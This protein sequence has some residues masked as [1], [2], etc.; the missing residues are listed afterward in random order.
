MHQQLARTRRN[1]KQV[2]PQTRK[3]PGSV[4]V[5]TL[6]LLVL[7]AM[8]GSAFLT[9][10]RA[11]RASV[12]QHATN[13]QGDMINSGVDAMIQA[14]LVRDLFDFSPATPTYRPAARE[15][16]SLPDDPSLA[17]R[18]PDFVPFRIAKT[19]KYARLP[20]WA[21]ISKPMTGGSSFEDPT[22]PFGKNTFTQDNSGFDPAGELKP[23][24]VSTQKRVGARVWPALGRL[25][26]TETID[27]VTKT[28][29]VVAM[30]TYVGADADND[31]LADSGLWRLGLG[32]IN[33]V[34]YY[35]GAR[36]VDHNSAVNSATA[37]RHVPGQAFDA[38]PTNVDFAQLM[39]AEDVQQDLARVGAYRDPSFNYLNDPE[40]MWLGLGSGLKVVPASDSMLLANPR[41]R[42]ERSV[43]ESLLVRTLG[44]GAYT[45]GPTDADK[46]FAQRYDYAQPNTRWS[47]WPLV[48]SSNPVAGVGPTRAR[49]DQH[50]FFESIGG[51]N[52]T[53]AVRTPVN[54]ATFPVLWRTFYD[55]IA[56]GNDAPMDGGT[57]DPFDLDSAMMFRSPIRDAGYVGGNAVQLPTSQVKL[58]RAAIAAVNAMDIRDADYKVTSKTLDLDV[59]GMGGR[60]KVTVFGCEPQPYITEV[61]ASTG[62]SDFDPEDP[63][64]VGKANPHGYV[65]VEL[66]N[67]FSFPIRLDGYRLAV[68]DRGAGAKAADGYAMDAIDSSVLDGVTVPAN[69]HVVLENLA[70]SDGNGAA[71]F[72][73]VMAKVKDTA[74][75]VF[76]SV[77]QLSKVFSDERDPSKH[78]GELVLLRPHTQSNGSLKSNMPV[79]Q[80]DFTGL[81]LK[82]DPT[83]R[84]AGVA[85]DEVEE[86]RRAK[87]AVWHYVRANGTR[88]SDTAQGNHWRFVYPGRY[89]T[90]RETTTQRETDAEDEKDASIGEPRHAL[91][92]NGGVWYVRDAARAVELAGDATL[93]KVSLGKP[94][95]KAN[96]VNRFPPIPV[97]AD[98]GAGQGDLDQFPFGGFARVG[99]VLKVPFIGA[100]TIEQGG[101]I[102][103]MN[104]VS[105]DS[106][107][108]DDAHAETDA[109]EHVG[110]FAPVQGKLA[111][112]TVVPKAPVVTAP[113]AGSKKQ[114]K[115]VTPAGYTDE[116][117]TFN[118]RPR[119]AA[120]HGSKLTVSKFRVGVAEQV[121]NQDAMQL[122]ITKWGSQPDQQWVYGE[123][124]LKDFEIGT[125]LH[126]PSLYV[127]QKLHCDHIQ[128]HFGG[129]AQPIKTRIHI[130]DGY[131]HGG[132]TDPLIIKDGRFSEVR[133]ENL[134]VDPKLAAIKISTENSGEIDVVRVV[135]SPNLKITIQGRRGVKGGNIHQ[136]VELFN[137]PGTTV[138]DEYGVGVEVKEM[139]SVPPVSGGDTGGAT[140]GNT[141]GKPTVPTAPAETTGTVVADVEDEA[142]AEFASG[143]HYAWAADVLEHFTTLTQEVDAKETQ[144]E[145]RR[146]DYRKMKLVLGRN[147]VTPEGIDVTDAR[148]VEGL[149]NLNTAPAP[150][151]AT[152]PM[153]LNPD[154]SINRVANLKLA[155]AIV[156]ARGTGKFTSLFE[157]MDVEAG[158][159]ESFANAWGTLRPDRDVR[160]AGLGDVSPADGT[161][162]DFEQAYLVLDRISNLVTLRSDTFTCYVVVQGW[163]NVGSE[164]AEVVSEKRWAFI[165]DRSQMRTPSD[166]LTIMQVKTQ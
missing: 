104:S 91:A 150:V 40:G 125:V 55:V 133:L 13:V 80:F 76:V 147:P 25:V 132:N 5:M 71:R 82:L 146:L 17:A 49:N 93:A 96:Y 74:G 18:A 160:N 2:K 128:L 68:L 136:G 86:A 28:K 38:F 52:G 50:A 85:V 53:E 135:D 36:V 15:G 72:R 122:K 12:T 123:I 126:D 22:L 130:Q 24:L 105:M 143:S 8:M 65:A 1:R 33:G 149:I 111:W 164:S 94:D 108:A 34:T 63:A 7:L 27:P 137:S 9:T 23:G 6:A 103:E 100:Y 92:R 89:D 162:N 66:H 151:I 90:K 148:P 60:V 37:W 152:L 41:N 145:P 57:N 155:E 154:G 140:G 77:P 67:P 113:K 121:V 88:G 78:G 101:K 31:G 61:F 46:Y 118:W 114:P 156:R 54:V 83:P 112:G 51:Y 141:T 153:V 45:F 47:R 58:L 70:G 139:T 43:T 117:A 84:S 97:N 20:H 166:A 64:A 110:R 127:G 144:Q 102:V 29:E 134:R 129:D 131:L 73:P 109:A 99:D 30:R 11:D 69:G 14:E 98:A 120:D 138:K 115:V 124:H 19:G 81:K 79:D 32:N 157:L 107:F 3:R 48:V 44:S 119:S 42:L 56:L 39:A 161:V 159:E 87:L 116:K 165:L 106:A 35:A 75:T 4:L 21:K 62:K 158:R 142:D 163:R 26:E 95:E 59:T 10:T 16:D